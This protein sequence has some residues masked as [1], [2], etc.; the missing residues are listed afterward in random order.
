M[1]KSSFE[2]SQEENKENIPPI[3]SKCTRLCETC[4]H[5]CDL[6]DKFRADPQFVIPTEENINYLLIAGDVVLQWVCPG[7]GVTNAVMDKPKWTKAYWN[8]K[9]AGCVLRS[10]N[11]IYSRGSTS[12]KRQRLLKDVSTQQLDGESSSYELDKSVDT[13]DFPSNESMVYGDEV[14]PKVDYENGDI[15]VKLPKS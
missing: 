5:K 7:G 2:E 14:D 9:T 10:R 13:S 12:I 8:F 1:D 11:L 15:W 6:V 3:T 4:I